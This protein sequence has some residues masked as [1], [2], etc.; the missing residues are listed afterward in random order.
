MGGSKMKMSDMVEKKHVS[1]KK[2]GC[3]WFRMWLSWWGICVDQYQ[4]KTAH[5]SM[6]HVVNQTVNEPLEATT[7]MRYI[8]CC[9]TRSIQLVAH[10]N[11][12]FKTNN[13]NP[14][15]II[16]HH[17]P[18]STTS[19]NRHQLSKK[20]NQPSKKTSSTIHKLQ[21][22]FNEPALTTNIQPLHSYPT[23]KQP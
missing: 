6:D 20:N 3:S 17:R 16:N 12:S 9:Q 11:P 19:K 10:E 13:N 18:S 22:T 21:L 4:I 1:S 15:P 14:S 5:G 2:C 23:L 8:D 7:I